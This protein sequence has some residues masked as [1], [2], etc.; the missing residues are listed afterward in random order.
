M[1]VLCI[2]TSYFPGP[3]FSFQDVKRVLTDFSGESFEDSFPYEDLRF[4]AH[5]FKTVSS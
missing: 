4:V 1:A 2:F 3:T 5:F